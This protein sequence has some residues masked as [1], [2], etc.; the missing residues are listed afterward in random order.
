MAVTSNWVLPDASS[1]R[2]SSALMHHV[3]LLPTMLHIATTSAGGDGSA[4]HSRKMPP[5]QGQQQTSTA[6]I[7]PPQ[8]T[9]P[10]QNLHRP[11]LLQRPLQAQQRLAAYGTDPG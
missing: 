2:D 3:D 1:G 6:E 9:E 5:T 11:A 7:D 4:V 8:V 10:I